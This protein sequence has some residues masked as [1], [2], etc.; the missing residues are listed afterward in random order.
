MLTK[1]IEGDLEDAINYSK[2]AIEMIEIPC[3]GRPAWISTLGD[4]LETRFERNGD[5]ADLE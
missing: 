3:D 4:N 5:M 1:E 2:F